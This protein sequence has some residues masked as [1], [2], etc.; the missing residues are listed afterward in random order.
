[1]AE[2]RANI[3]LITTDQPIDD[4]I[5]RTNPRSGTPN[6]DRPPRRAMTFLR[7]FPVNPMCPSS[8][9]SI[10]TEV[11]PSAPG[12]WRIGVKLPEDV[13]IVGAMFPRAGYSRTLI[14]KAHFQPTGGS[15]RASRAWPDR[16]VRLIAAP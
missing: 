13:P 10:I 5:G 15:R 9:A 8:R 11:Y 12:C 7:A 3:L 2:I 6:L 1:M 14:G 4:T 16:E